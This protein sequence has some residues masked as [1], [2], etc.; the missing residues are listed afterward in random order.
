MK[1]VL[2]GMLILIAAV[3]VIATAGIAVTWAPDRGLDELRAR[4]A[5][6]PS[7]FITVDG[8]SVHLRDEGPR[9]D[10]L[11]IV[12]LH[13]TS[14]SLHT[15]DGWAAALAPHRRVIRMDMPGFG[16]TGPTPDND[17]SIERYVRFVTAVTDALGVKQFVLA[18]NS[19]GG[20]IAWRTA[21]AHPER[22]RKLILVD[23][24]GYP[25]PDKGMPIGFRIAKTPVLNRI[26]ELT[27]PRGMVE[28]SVRDVYGDP[29][30]V[31]P[32]LVD[33]YYE[34]TLRAGN[35]AALRER[36][37]QQPSGADAAQIATIRQPTLILWGGRDHLIVP[38]DAM[39]FA[40]D[41]PGSKLVM[42]DTLGHV[43]QEENP[44]GTVAA[45]KLFL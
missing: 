10:A 41:I 19:L 33:R 18:G 35:R 24:G 9:D 13:G 39:R 26:M 32:A 14:A 25:L 4:W 16:L 15:W 44:A 7:Q 38:A 29:A 22:V 36:F 31:T 6:P 30:K 21:V 45:V 5:P 27:L 34:L 1:R 23:A 42:F 43:P 37:R 3:A 11:P 17:Y 2:K 8:M 20:H 28:A 40:Q 12:L